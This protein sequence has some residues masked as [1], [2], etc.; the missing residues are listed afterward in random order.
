MDFDKF[1]AINDE[2][3]N[4]GVMNAPTAVKRFRNDA[5]GDDYVIYIRLE[6]EHVVDA[7]FTT[8][9]C[10]FGLAALSLAAEWIKGKNLE[11]AEQITVADVEAGIDGFPERR[12]HYPEKAVEIFR[13]TIRECREAI[14][15]NCQNL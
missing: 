2:Q 7:S 13:K 11:E 4:V 6:G 5:C 12:M 15:R 1:K 8:T 3:R 9:G 14:L 10:G